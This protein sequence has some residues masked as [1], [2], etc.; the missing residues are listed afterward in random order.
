LVNI[1][2]SLIDDQTA[3][4]TLDVLADL[5]HKLIC[6]DLLQNE[7]SD[8]YKVSGKML[9]YLM[10]DPSLVLTEFFEVE[11]YRTKEDVD[12]CNYYLNSGGVKDLSIQNVT[13]FIEMGGNGLK[14]RIR[15]V[16]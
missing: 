15:L 12:F 6:T 4:D 13:R 1:V 9:T 11:I 16:E 2:K 3:Q 14:N 8:T 10:N 5:E 7:F